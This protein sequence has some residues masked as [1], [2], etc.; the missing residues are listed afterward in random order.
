MK[1]AE[2]QGIRVPVLGLGTWQLEGK[3]CQRAVEEALDMGYR[4]VDTAQLYG[5]EA[6][7]GRALRASGLPRED[8]FLTTK[9]WMESLDR[10]SVLRT[11]GESLRRLDTDYVD[12]LLIHW[13]NK[14]VPLEETLGAFRQ[15]QDEGKAKSIG[16]SNFPP[17]L[18]RRALEIAPIV[19]NQ[20]EFHPYLGQTALLDL[21]RQHDLLLTA[22]SPLARG[23]VNQD[24]TLQE[25]GK[26]HGKT[27][28]QVTLRWL[29]QQDHVAAIPKASSPG[30]LRANLEIF[31]F[32]LSDEEMRR[33]SDLDRGRR[34]IDPPS[35]PDWE[36]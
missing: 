33:I 9:I 14:A 21:A 30:H 7:V 13:P 28:S 3:A 24:K 2:I 15:L 23:E 34:L 31:D 16:V 17:S 18:L 20:V 36:R 12:L 27:P 8:I 5:N 4:H 32:V 10:A 1:H 6:E 22:Y 26:R 25:I 11:G 29:V 35:A 19:C